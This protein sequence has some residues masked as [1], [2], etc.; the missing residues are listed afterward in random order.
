MTDDNL[1]RSRSRYAAYVALRSPPVSQPARTRHFP[2]PRHPA[3]TNFATA[4]QS[5]IRPIMLQPVD[6]SG[7][8]LFW[9]WI[10]HFLPDFYRSDLR[11]YLTTRLGLNN[12][13]PSKSVEFFL[14][15][16]R[17]KDLF[18]KQLGPADY[19][20]WRDALLDL[21][22]IFD[23]VLARLCLSG[24]PLKPVPVATFRKYRESHIPWL[25]HQFPCSSVMA[26][27]YP[28]VPPL[29]ATSCLY[30]SREMGGEEAPLRRAEQYG[31]RTATQLWIEDAHL[32][33]GYL[34]E[35]SVP[36][37]GKRGGKRR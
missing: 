2:S 30:V 34:T 32:S 36:L 8:E 18:R 7:H 21:K 19:L 6:F 14:V 17:A 11:Y 16:L 10:C 25:R 13:S 22:I 3:S 9:N 33:L 37:L 20:Q 27:R 23:F 26:A 28:S 24:T 29:P 4:S 35:K 1:L 12:Q 5:N 31:E 15:L